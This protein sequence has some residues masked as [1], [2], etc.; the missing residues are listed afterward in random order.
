MRASVQVTGLE[1]SVRVDVLIRVEVDEASPFFDP[2]ASGLSRRE[3][4]S[5]KIREGQ[6][7]LAAAWGGTISSVCEIPRDIENGGV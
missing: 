7:E 1:A 5:K 6:P 2:G 3:M 4:V